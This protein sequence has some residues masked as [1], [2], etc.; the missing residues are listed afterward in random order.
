MSTAGSGNA[1]SFD[2]IDLH[3]LLLTGERFTFQ[4]LPSHRGKEVRKLVSRQLSKK[5]RTL[6]LHHKT[7]P[8]LFHQTLQEQGIG[9]NADLSCTFLPTNLCAAWCFV[10]GFHTAEEEFAMEGLTS[11]RRW[12]FAKPVQDPPKPDFWSRIQP[13]NAPC[14]LS[15]QSSKPSFRSELQQKHA[16]SHVA[17][18]SSM[19]DFWRF[20]QPKHA[21]SHVARQSW[22]L[23][24]WSWLQPQN[25]GSHVSPE[26]TKIES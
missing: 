4:A 20:F 8:L 16:G 9:P 1:N 2:L 26:C 7:S 5:G 23:G 19:P 22:E 10:K 17:R 14:D 18:Q 6:T 13:E 15:R 3:V 21:G 24:F 25:A 12:L 11:T